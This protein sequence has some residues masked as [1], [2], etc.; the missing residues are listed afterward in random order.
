MTL[1]QRGRGSL[2]TQMLASLWTAVNRVRAVIEF[3]MQGNILSANELFL[4][5]S[6]YTLDEIVG[7]HHALFC[8]PDFVAS[9]TYRQ[10]WAGLGLGEFAAGE[11]KR[12]GKGGREVW[13]Q[14]SYNPIMDA[15]GRPTRVVKFATDVTAA[16]MANAEFQG[17]VNAI[18]RAQGV[19]EFDLQGNIL[20]ANEN[21]LATLGYTLAEVAGKHH[22]MFCAE[23][24]IVS[25]A[26]R[27]F[28]LKLSRGDFEAGRFMRI[29]K[30]GRKVWIQASY[31]PI[32]DMNGRPYKVV[33]FAIDI[34]AQVEL[35][36]R[37]QTRTT[38]MTEV[39]HHLTGS[40]NAIAKNTAS[41]LALAHETQVQAEAGVEALVKSVEAMQAIQ[42]STEDIDDIVKVIGEI[43]NQT[44]LLAFNAAIEAARAGEHGLGFSVVAD[45]VR[46]LAEKSS[47]A[48]REI[49]KLLSESVKRVAV[50]DDVS[51]KAGEA[52]ERIVGGVAKTSST[53]TDINL[54]TE[55]QLAAAQEVGTLIRDLNAGS[56]PAA[57]L[58]AAA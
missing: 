7:K 42:K 9:E 56:G 39:V 36:Q 51:R 10:F 19:I 20:T 25:T 24:F 58:V 17:K 38:S 14:A 34:T 33:K 27:D 45:E 48:T 54:A 15:E 18:D 5:A 28:W 43:A 41:A 31:N 26:Y 49:N 57:T 47:Q 37:I 13:L 2:D 32:F 4:A 40:I 46:K 11:Y 29:G 30:F 21:F 55:Q 23:D 44:N 8:E 50:G 53:I 6:G 16:K 3:D 1:Q 35:E 22:S 52:F 12:L